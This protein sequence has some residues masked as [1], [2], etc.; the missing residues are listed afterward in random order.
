MTK[1]L[2]NFERENSF[3]LF[4][5]VIER[6]QKDAEKKSSLIYLNTYILTGAYV[7]AIFICYILLGWTLVSYNSKIMHLF[8]QAGSFKKNQILDLVKKNNRNFSKLNNLSNSFNL[9][10]LK[11]V[12]SYTK[13]QFISIAKS[14]NNNKFRNKKMKSKM[15]IVNPFRSKQKNNVSTT[16]LLNIGKH[17]QTNKMNNKKTTI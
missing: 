1:I 10:E 16:S 7:V 2:S 6:L 17:L 8:K 9:Q 11:E 13:N 5:L 15:N 12:K 4:E 14:L 3:R